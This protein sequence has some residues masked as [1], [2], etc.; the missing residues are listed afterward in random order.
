MEFA[1][2][3]DARHAFKSLAYKKYHHVPLY[4]EWAPKD[5]FHHAPPL[6][7]T[8]DASK[9][10]K[11]GSSATAAKSQSKDVRAGVAAPSSSHGATDEEGGGGG[12]SSSHSI[13]VK[14]LAFATTDESL[15]K[16]FDRSVSSCGGFIRSAK[17]GL[18]EV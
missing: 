18:F 14:N 7:H 13:F 15:R 6:A 3:Q 12:G 5:I 2:P 10:S 8:S 11:P 17:V 1:E 16:H 4:L 9:G